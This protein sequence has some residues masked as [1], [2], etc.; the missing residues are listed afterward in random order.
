[1]QPDLDE[2]SAGRTGKKY[3]KNIYITILFNLANNDRLLDWNDNMLKYD[4]HY[5]IS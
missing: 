2:L 5:Y 1:V 3:L 4:Q